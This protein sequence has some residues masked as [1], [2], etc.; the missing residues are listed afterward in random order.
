MRVD[1][2]AELLESAGLR[3]IELREGFG[4]GFGG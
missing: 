1:Q 3:P 4:P 2:L